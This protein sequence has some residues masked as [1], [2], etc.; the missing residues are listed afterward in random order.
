[1]EGLIQDVRFALRVLR[2]SPGFTAVA[3]LIMTLGIGANTAI[4]SLTQ[5]VLLRNLPIT[6]PDQLVLLTFEKP[7]QSL[8]VPGPLFNAIE[9]RQQVYSSMFAWYSSTLAVKQNG[10]AR[11]I[12]G[13]VVSGETFPTLGLRPA[14]GRLISPQDDQTGGGAGSWA[15]VISYDYWQQNFQGE[16]NAIGKSLEVEN[17]PVTVVG[18]APRG[19]SSVVMG[20]KPQIFLPLNFEAQWHAKSPRIKMQG[21]LFLTV[22]GRLKPG[23]TLAQAVTDLERIKPE[24]FQEADSTHAL[25]TFFPD[26]KLTLAPGRSGRAWMR[27]QYRVPLL[28]LQGLVG[29]VLL[30]CCSNLTMLLLARA[31]SRR[32]EIAVRSALGADRWRLVRQLL[33]ESFLVSATGAAIGLWFAQ[34]ASLAL[35]NALGS[36]G[37]FFLDLHPDKN[38]LLFTA[39]IAFITALLSGL[40]PGLQATRVDV[41]TDLKESS[42]TSQG[43]RSMRAERWLLAGQVGFSVTIL[44]VA[45]LF[46]GTLYRLLSMDPG[47]RTTGVVVVPTDFKSLQL[48][49]KDR[50]EMYGRLIE[51]LN[52]MPGIERASMEEMSPLTGWSSSIALAAVG[53]GGEEGKHG[54]TFYNSVGPNYFGT[55]GT[56]ILAGHDFSEH[57]IV[58]G[59]MVCVVNVTAAKYFF[60][61]ENAVGRSLRDAGANAGGSAGENGKSGSVYEIVGM[62]EDSKFTSLRAP[63]PPT[64]YFPFT[65][66]HSQNLSPHFV[67]RVNNA[68]AAIASYRQVAKEFAPAAPFLQPITMREQVRESIGLDLTLGMLSGFFGVVALLLTAIGLY[69][70]LAFSVSRRTPEIGIRMALGAQR[71]HI[72]KNVVR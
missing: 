49:D 1:M 39:A 51:R 41:V 69:G 65:Q 58:A 21:G 63:A 38:V 23:A 61:G 22:M 53:T 28:V 12:Q 9:K 2:R 34:S 43:A 54:T 11:Q 20:S 7:G 25:K 48:N 42:A 15:A 59:R 24:V 37:S 31:S 50:A 70:L 52:S 19:F 71:F 3:L 33:V 72:I 45:T 46:A 36:R 32:H 29:L 4:F 47:Y 6:Q 66:V 17:I 8:G 35:L 62:A 16:Q 26:V 56:R 55:R 14:A 18:V 67:L 68:A 5:A 60:G 30:I 64:V 10:E 40:L 44:I 13:A 57:D 27:V